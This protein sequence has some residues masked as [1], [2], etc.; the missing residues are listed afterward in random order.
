[1]NH[2]GYKTCAQRHSNATLPDIPSIDG[3][4][5]RLR[6]PIIAAAVLF[7]IAVLIGPVVT[8]ASEGAD[9]RAAEPGEYEGAP[10]LDRPGEKLG[11]T[12]LAAQGP[13]C[14]ALSLP[15]AKKP[16]GQDEA[17]HAFDAMFRAITTCST[18]KK[19]TAG[20][21]CRHTAHKV[22]GNRTF[23]DRAPPGGL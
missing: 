7:A 4:I 5:N 13:C 12:W 10:L 20:E 9:S 1:M 6:L 21:V 23:K 2:P 15:G 19:Q 16:Q 3:L 8:D 11:F 17:I 18:E 22:Y 14:E